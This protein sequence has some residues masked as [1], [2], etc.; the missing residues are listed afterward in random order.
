MTR[1]VTRLESGGRGEDRLLVARAGARTL[2]VVADGAGGTGRG[3]AAAEI[4][5][6]M[7][8]DAFHRG[9]TSA[10]LW[11]RTLSAVDVQLTRRGGQS[12][13]VVLEID[14]DT[15]SGAS[16]GDSEAWALGSAGSVDLT[17]QQQRKPLLGTGQ[18]VPMTIRP[19][20]M[21]DRILVATD[22]LMK[23]CPRAEVDRLA[24]AGT[25]EEAVEALLSRVR[26]RSGKLQDD[27]A[28]VLCDAG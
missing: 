18:A 17:S 9:S 20:A 8:L 3:A 22:G 2:I 6:S 1:A 15:V 12:T 21:P 5:C 25:L 26:L 27:V 4:T 11:V 24:R 14:R 16:V 19:I 13:V 10:R 7:V 28:I 23:Y